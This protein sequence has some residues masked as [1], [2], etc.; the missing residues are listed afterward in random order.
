MGVEPLQQVRRE[1]HSFA[2]LAID[3]ACAIEPFFQLARY[4]KTRF[5]GGRLRY[6]AFAPSDTGT[7]SRSLSDFTM[8]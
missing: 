4:L 3:P 1:A 5:A 7:T 6:F 2:R 8:S